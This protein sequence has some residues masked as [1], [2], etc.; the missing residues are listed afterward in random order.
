[1]G[2]FPTASSP[3]DLLSLAVGPSSNILLNL[4]R[5]LRPDLLEVP[6]QQLS[7]VLGEPCQLQLRDGLL[8]D[9]LELEC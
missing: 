9:R 8:E 2:L 1:M 7:L 4:G 6:E 3:R 5:N